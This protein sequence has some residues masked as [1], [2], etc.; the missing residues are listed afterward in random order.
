MGNILTQ[1]TDY[2]LTQSWHIAMLA[3]V[4]GAVSL[5]LKNRSAH[6]R[7]LLWVVILGK[8]LMPPLLTIPLAI[9]PQ[10]QIAEPVAT[11]AV[12]AEEVSFEAEDAAVTVELDLGTAD[13]AAEPSIIRR[14]ADVSLRQWLAFG[15]IVGAGIFFLIALI[16]A[17]RV[18][19]WLRGQRKP[20]SGELQGMIE[21]LFAGLGI[22]RFPKV[23][24][25]EGIGQ[26]F[27]WGLVRGD[28]YLPGNFAQND[29][30]DNSRGVLGHELSHILR[31]DAAVNLLQI[32][33]QGIFWFHPFVWWANKK[34][35][36]EREKCCDEMAIARLDAKAKEYSSAIVDVLVAEYE[37]SRPIPSLAIAG[38][39]KNIE[40]RI[41]TIM[42]PGKKFYKYPSI[43][44]AITI[45]LLGLI[46]VPTTLALTSQPAKKT[47][48]QAESSA[49]TGQMGTTDVNDIESLAP[50]V[51]KLGEAVR[52]RLTTYSDEE[53][54]TLQDGETAK[55]KVKENIAGVAEILI[56]PHI[57][58]DGTKLNLKTLD[59]KGNIIAE[60][61]TRAIHDGDSE[62]TGL[63]ANIL[64]DGKQILCKIQLSPTRQGTDSVV[65]TVKALFTEL[66]S[67]EELQA[68]L[69]TRGKEGRVQLDF[70]DISAA[71]IEYK[72]QHD[73]YPE[74]LEE[75]NQPLPKD[76]YS[77]SGQDYQYESNQERFIL[78]SC[79]EDGVYGNNDDRVSISYHNRTL[80]GQR[81]EFYPLE[82]NGSKTQTET[83]RGERPRGNCSISGRVISADT[84]EPVGHARVYLFYLGTH[85]SIFI[86]VASDGSFVFKDIPTGPFSLKTTRTAGYQDD[87]YNPENKLSYPQ[88]SLEDGE[89]RS[90][91]ILEVE[92]AFRISGKVLDENGKSLKDSQLSVLAWV[93]LDEPEGNLNRYK[94][95]QQ[96]RIASDGSY[97][98]DG[99]DDRPVYI[100]TIDWNAENKDDYYP[101][102]YYPGTVARNEAEKVSFEKTKFVDGI[103]IHLK[104]EGEF[105]LEGVVT[106][107]TTSKAVPKTLVTIHHRDMLFDRLT[108]YTDEQGHY[109]VESLGAGDFL[110]H[111]DAEPW[112]YVRTR[113]PVKIETVK[114][115]KLDFT[116]R[117][118]AKISGKIVDENGNPT[119]ISPRAYG[120]AYRYGYST[121]ETMSWSGA[122]NRYDIKSKEGLGLE[123]TFNGGEGDYE[124]EYMDFPTLSTF[125]IEGMIP[126]KTVLRFHPKSQGQTLKEILYNGQNIMETGIETKPGEEIKDVTIV[127]DTGSKI[128]Q[129]YDVQRNEKAKI[130]IESRFIVFQPDSNE[131]KDFFESEDL[132]FIQGKSDPN[133][134]TYFA[135]DEQVDELLRL[136][137]AE[138]GS[139]VLAAPRVL[140]LDG[141][142]A[143]LRIQRTV[144]YISG[145]SEPNEPLDEPEPIY[146]EFLSGTIFQARPKLEAGGEHILL[147][148]DI[149]LREILGWENGLPN[150]Q[151]IRIQSRFSVLN[152]QT[153]LLEGHKINTEKDGEILEKELFV[154]I[155]AEQVEQ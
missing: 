48:G 115:T 67:W 74:N 29:N 126:G 24:L 18:N 89:Q 90:D 76:V 36:A 139:K 134:M 23:W 93:E 35:R 19:V 5:L 149:E 6:I 95:A 124:E 38:P 109:L 62:R 28:I 151:I 106:D 3:L 53:T 1:I 79:G 123:D 104:K 147:E 27:V 46:I 132:E 58:A 137:Q 68:M 145:Y 155:R 135:T 119:E 59:D 142:S 30:G 110:V 57:V 8:C 136:I 81:H 11:T 10:G 66:S 73:R 117:P 41:K 65:V 150:A 37:S 154:L 75:L 55:M 118:A 69:L 103:D 17:F 77:Q 153:L 114:V 94:I 15:W 152:G 21:E 44:A 87:V 20:V 45:L 96:K 92:P 100:M 43:L 111:I 33:A 83:V 129:N 101:P 141:E 105:I 61:T 4:I 84:G 56:T 70:A 12:A 78:S 2:L 72:Q 16:K 122:N 80:S 108:T 34:I 50:N 54:F 120:L 25:I 99:L 86:N 32:I 26:P 102:C 116:L 148:C 133:L 125:V 98:L 85:A 71:I 14:L 138:S 143:T 130:Q 42:Q 22:K 82:D 128:K 51:E 140:V 39:V 60:S 64:K 63:G 52:K 97:L 13:I 40:D 144:R 47:N 113:K 9:L 131:I 91:V 88:F 107:E 127:I 7:Y 146:D 49:E 121:P 31:F 112:G